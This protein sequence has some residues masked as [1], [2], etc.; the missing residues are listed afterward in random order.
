[1]LNLRTPRNSKSLNSQG[2]YHFVYSERFHVFG[3]STSEI[4]RHLPLLILERAVIRTL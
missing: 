2:A 3:E 1:M 4:R